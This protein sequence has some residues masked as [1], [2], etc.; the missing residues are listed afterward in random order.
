MAAERAD[1]TGEAGQCP[2]QAGIVMRKRA[3]Q[4]WQLDCGEAGAVSS[5]TS[6]IKQALCCEKRMIRKM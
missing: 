2:V 1:H 6:L 4:S 5:R 3:G